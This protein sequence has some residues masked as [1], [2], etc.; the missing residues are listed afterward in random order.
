M[1]FVRTLFL[2]Q[3]QRRGGSSQDVSATTATTTQQQN[4][5][6]PTSSELT[7]VVGA[8]S[9]KV[10]TKKKKNKKPRAQQQ[11]QHDGVAAVAVSTPTVA[12]PT[13]TTTTTT[14]TRSLTYKEQVVAEYLRRM[15]Q[16]D[17]TTGQL[18]TDQADVIF[19]ETPMTPQ[20]LEEE[21]VKVFRSFPDFTLH[22]VS[23]NGIVEQPDGT[24]LAELEATGT[25]T[26]APYSF[27]PYPDI[28]P[29]GITVKLDREICR[30]HICEKE[31]KLSKI[32]ITPLG[33]SSG[34][35]GLYTLIG[36]LIF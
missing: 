26:G 35:P 24:V 1:N 29:S 30:Y 10:P 25:H 7:V 15:N 16:H 9:T 31:G 6:H 34:P 11:Q 33:Q 14:T 5:H 13:T 17:V 20:S 12:T 36:G 4:H 21:M 8:Q 18:F 27:G 28:P 23:V 2:R 32:I 3:P 19:I 22:I